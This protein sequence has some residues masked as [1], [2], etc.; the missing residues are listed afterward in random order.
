VADE[1]A[2]DPK[3]GPGFSDSARR[4]GGPAG[5]VAQR[6]SRFQAGPEA[7]IDPNDDID[8]NGLRPRLHDDVEQI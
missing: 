2:E 8:P 5:V 7:D 1:D 4:G 3:A 6:R